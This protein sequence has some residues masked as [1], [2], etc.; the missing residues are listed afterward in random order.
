VA[1]WF[2]GARLGLFVHWDHASAQGL[3]LSWPMVGGVF[4]LPKCQDVSVAEY[5]RSATTFDPDAWEPRAL[6]ALARRAGAGYGVFTAKHHAGYAMYPTA[7]SDWSVAASPCRRDLV[8]EWVEALRAEGLRVGLYFSLS[9]WHHPDYPAFTDD[10]RPY[11]PG[12]SPPVPPLEQA[13]RYRAFLRAQLRELL[14]NY[15]PID[16]LWFDGGWERP[17]EWWGSE[18]LEA[19]IRGLQPDIR[20]NDRLP[21]VGDFATPEQFVPPEPP[22]GP[23]ETCLTMNDS[24]GYVPTDT[25]YKS[26][27]ELVHTLSEVASRGG[28]LLVNVSPTGSGAL[29]PPQLERLQGLAEWMA[30]HGESILGTEPGLAPWQFYGP[31]TRRGNVFYLHLLLRPYT[32]VS[33]RGVPVRRVREVRVLGPDRPLEFRFRTAVLDQLNADP[34][35]ELIVAVPEDALDPLATVLRVD[36][37]DGV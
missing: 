22:D 32:T 7:Q 25:D 29:P 26:V 30:L 15:G 6:A 8:R 10:S 12:F 18:E 21:G 31:S 23:W 19:M 17:P 24:W 5:D 4:A 3:E 33:V 27:R 2:A 16:V 1:D 37:A 34:T 36:F 13:D 11:V 35:G 28:N 14:T 9:D 20:I